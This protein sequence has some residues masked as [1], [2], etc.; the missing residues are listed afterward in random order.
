MTAAATGAVVT[1]RTVS[2]AA[3]VTPGVTSAPPAR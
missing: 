1:K 2:A 3:V